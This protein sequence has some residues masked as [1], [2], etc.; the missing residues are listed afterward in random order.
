[1]VWVATSQLGRLQSP[2]MSSGSISTRP[3]STISWAAATSYTAR[4]SS[5][6]STRE[7]SPSGS[8]RSLMGPYQTIDPAFASHPFRAESAQSDTRTT[9]SRRKVTAESRR[10]VT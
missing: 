9:P 3:T 5:M 2:M 6:V 8:V 10:V 4:A 7:V 1:M